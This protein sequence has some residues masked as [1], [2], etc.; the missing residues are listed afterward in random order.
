MSSALQANAIATAIAIA[1]VADATLLL[2]G[3]VFAMSFGP[4]RRLLETRRMLDEVKLD[5]PL[6]PHVPL[7]I[8]GS[9]MLFALLLPQHHV[10]LQRFLRFQIGRV[11]TVIYQ[12]QREVRR[13]VRELRG[14][15]FLVA[16]LFLVGVIERLG[17][18]GDQ[19]SFQALWLDIGTHPLNGFDV[20]A[21]VALAFVLFRLVAELSRID[22]LL[23]SVDS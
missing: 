6:G 13:M 1:M 20:V 14:Y 15:S 19:R 18:L 16:I 17:A 3:G 22:D 8:L 4:V 12:D 10:P 9:T 5:Q 11:F 2:G 21:L 7:I 23:I